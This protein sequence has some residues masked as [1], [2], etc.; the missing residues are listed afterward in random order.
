MP[1]LVLP[2]T[3]VCPAVPLALT[4]AGISSEQM[5]GGEGLE[6]LSGLPAVMAA[7]WCCEM[8]VDWIKHAFIVKFN[9]IP[10]HVR[11]SCSAACP[12][13]EYVRVCTVWLHIIGNAEHMH[14]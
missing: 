8:V 9:S 10:A 3:V 13:C 14:E 4:A 1:I 11:E 12:V 5:V 2:L 6:L 7:L